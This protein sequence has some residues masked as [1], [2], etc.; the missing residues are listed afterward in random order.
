MATV[1]LAEDTKSGQR[2]A[3]KVL[4]ELTAILGRPVFIERS[5]FSAGSS[6]RTSCRY[7]TR[8]RRD[9]DST[10]RHAVCLRGQRSATGWRRQ[11]PLRWDNDVIRIAG[12]V[13]GA[14]DYAHGQGVLHRDIKPENVLLEGNRVLVCDFGVARAIE[15]GWWG[16]QLVQWTRCGYTDVHESGAGGPVSVPSAVGYLCARLCGIRDARRRATIRRTDGTG[17][18]RTEAQ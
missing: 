10:E 7:W 17:H 3:V 6:T 9:Q 16:I 12:D 13:A 5:R 8:E 15:V 11:G 14:I 2:V 18:T 1:Y 4:Q